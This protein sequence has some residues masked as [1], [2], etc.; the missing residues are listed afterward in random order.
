MKFK[1]Y[2]FKKK[3]FRLRLN[4]FDTLKN[5]KNLGLWRNLKEQ[6]LIFS[7]LE[8]GKITF[9]KYIFGSSYYYAELIIH[10]YCVEI[11]LPRWLGGEILENV[12]NPT[13]SKITKPLP[14]LW[15]KVLENENFTVNKWSIK[16]KFMLFILLKFLQNIRY[17]FSVIF[18]SIKRLS[19]KFNNEKTVFFWD[20]TA[21][22]FPPN[23][24]SDY[25]FDIFSWY[26][27]SN[28]FNNKIQTIYHSVKEKDDMI[29]KNVEIKY[30]CPPTSYINDKLSLLKFIIW[31]IFATALSF[32]DLIM[33]KWY[34]ALILGEAVK[35]KIIE[36]RKFDELSIAYYFPYSSPCYRPMWTYGA[37]EK[38]TEIVS[39]FYSTFE[40]P[41]VN[42][43]L[44]NQKFEFYL[45]NWPIS[46]V[47]DEAQSNLLKVNSKFI[48]N[49][50]VVGP[51]FDTDSQGSIPQN[52]NFTIAIFDN[53][54]HKKSFEFGFLTFSE[55]YEYNKDGNLLFLKD[56]ISCAE[57]LSISILHKT[58][59]NIGRKVVE[60][61]SNY[62]A[63]LNENINYFPIEPSVSAIKVIDKADM[64]IS[65]PFT[66]TALYGSMRNKPTFYYDPTGW[67][68]KDD[69][70]AHG[71][72]VI[73]G[74]TE[75]KQII[76]N[77]LQKNLGKNL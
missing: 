44:N 5:E 12:A 65:S 42:K 49:E 73:V 77:I 11:F 1:K 43:L 74:I 53:Q 29:Y 47:W 75:L 26:I 38:G 45:Y 21:K 32:F 31:S 4:G 7:P 22:N 64:V 30:N 17:I 57:F 62:L 19:N 61:Y 27:E 63:K 37:F 2:N 51:I 6:F 39:Y 71:I 59:R 10:Q 15:V 34:H 35:N 36:L 60:S 50:K 41:K 76:E 66:S 70:A 33:G 14:S 24:N 48:I 13:K 23:L 25:N 20:L 18:R 16:L 46:L 54:M 56:I 68:Q 69:P 58:K 55:Y 8:K 3:K 9:Y 72:P 28:V 67:I 52:K 40:Q